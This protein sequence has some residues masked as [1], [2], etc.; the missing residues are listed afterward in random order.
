MADAVK[1]TPLALLYD[2]H[3]NLPALEAVLDEARAAGAA[4]YLLG[5][6]YA[7]FGPWPRETAERLEGLP[8]VARI[9]GNA[10]RWLREE[11]QVP[12]EAEQLVHAALTAARDSLGPELVARLYDLP[13][14][15]EIDG[16]L[17]C[18]GSP[19]SDI[20]S[21]AP[22]PQAGEERM[23]AGEAKRTILFGHSH[24]QFQRPG[25]DDTFLVNPGSVGMPLDGDPRA[26][27]ALYEN[28]RI[29]FR[30]TEYDIERAAAQMGSY[31]DWAKPIV[32]R[33]EQGSD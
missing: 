29:L 21:F 28:G 30:R 24:Q 2:I 12:S 31:G 18:H 15:A 16:V 27:W 5:G 17:V 19:L 8:A 25:P 33:I 7:A 11:P 26:A 3:G 6:D 20:E 10:E 22:E 14:Q 32:R 1:R 9:R 13:E 23:L 4:S